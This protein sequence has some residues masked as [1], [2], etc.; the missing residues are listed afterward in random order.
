M[1]STARFQRGH[2]SLFY[3]QKI[4]FFTAYGLANFKLFLVTSG[5]HLATLGLNDPAL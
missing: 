5:F 4:T 1:M 2:F 3:L